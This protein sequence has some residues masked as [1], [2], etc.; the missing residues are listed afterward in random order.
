MFCEGSDEIWKELQDI[1]VE[2]SFDQE[3]SIYYSS[4]RWM[5]ARKV[6]EVGSGTGYHTRCL[7]HH[8]SDKEYHG[9]DTLK[10]LVDHARKVNSSAN[11]EFECRD[12]FDVCGRYDAIVMRLFLQHLDNPV[13]ALVHAKSMLNSGGI[14]IIIDACDDYRLY[15]P[16]APLY[17]E[18]FRRYAELQYRDG[19]NRRII[20]SIES[21]AS[22]LNVDFIENGTHVIPST[23]QNNFDLLWRTY[24]LF[25]SLV[26]RSGYMKGYDFEMVSNEWENWKHLPNA[27]TQ[28][29]ISYILLGVD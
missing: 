15:V 11:I 17:L 9:V 14:I 16:N 10:P 25:L 24:S 19:R 29:A 6:L 18:F 12:Y 8:F 13:D 26:E 4:D 22:E 28:V 2:F 1:Q 5:S 21:M 7:H 20:D 23:L 3:V 27:Y